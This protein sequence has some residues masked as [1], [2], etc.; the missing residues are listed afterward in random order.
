MKNNYAQI[1]RSLQLKWQN[2]CFIA[3][4][5]NSSF[6]NQSH[7]VVDEIFLKILDDL[8]LK[9]IPIN[10]NSGPN[11]APRIFSE[12]PQANGISKLAFRR[13]MHRL[14]QMGKIESVKDKRSS[15]IR[16]AHA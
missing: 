14:R 2:G 3:D 8:T 11:Y 12:H 4:G 1:G 5:E 15:H 9:G 16:R 13:A 6:T 7:Q 10:A